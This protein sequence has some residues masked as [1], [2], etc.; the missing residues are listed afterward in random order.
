VKVVGIIGYKNSGKTALILNLSRELAR[1]GWK[2]AVLK[3]TRGDLDVP[4]KDTARHM[5][6]A[7]QVAAIS[8]KGSAIFFKGKR[9]L[10]DMLGYLDADLVLIEGMKSEKTF[11]KVVCLKEKKDAQ[12]LFDGLEVCVATLSPLG[13][14]LEVPVFHILDDV[15][16]IADMIV[17]RAFKL[18]NLNCGGCGYEKCYDLARE[19]CKGRKKAEDCVSLNPSIEVLLDGQVLATNPF[20][21][22]VIR[23]AIKGMLSG[24]K[25]FKPGEIEIRI[26]REED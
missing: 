20:V 13:L 25:G 12:E 7:H 15:K 4:H 23:G 21:S 5:E 9:S 26:G 1:M 24:L 10:E 3:H 18:P 19:I 8:P 17:E 16:K 11:P 22:K 6:H 14:G 2:V